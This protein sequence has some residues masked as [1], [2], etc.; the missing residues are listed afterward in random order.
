MV[1]T[2]PSCHNRESIQD[3]FGLH[4]FSSCV[5]R[6]P[7]IEA[8]DVLRLQ[9]VEVERNPN[10]AKYDFKVY[11]EE[12]VTVLRQHRDGRLMLVKSD[13]PSAGQ[14]Q[15]EDRDQMKHL[16]RWWN[17]EQNGQVRSKFP[18]SKHCVCDTYC[19]LFF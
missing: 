14:L 18:E 3:D 4:I 10:S 5:E 8:G 11:G 7:I 15:D 2:D 1:L 13:Y 6:Y 19:W 16:I 9:N 12:L 17:K